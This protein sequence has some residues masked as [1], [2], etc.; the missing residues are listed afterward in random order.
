MKLVW[1]VNYILPQIAEFLGKKKGVIGGWTVRLADM[2]AENPDID[3]TVFYPQSEQR[4]NITGKAGYISFVG[5][6]ENAIPELYYNPGITERIKAELDRI[7]P[8]IVHIWG[9]EYVHTLSMVRAFNR[10]ERTVISIQ[11]LIH[12]LGS[13]YNAG[14]PE[15]I[16]KRH[17]FRDFIRQDSI[18]QQKEKFLKRGECE[19]AALREV[20]HVIGRTGWDEKSVKEVNPEVCYHHAGEI[21]RKAFYDAGFVWRPE[22]AE[23][24]RIFMTQS[25]YPIKGI[26]FV[27]EALSSVKKTFPDIKLAVTGIDMRPDSFKSRIKQDSYGKYVC[28]LI[29]E[30]GLNYNIEFLGE[31]F[32]DDMVKQY[33]RSSA[34]LLPSVME[35]SS[36]SLG[37]AMMLGVPCI[38][39]RTGGT[40]DMICEDEGWLYDHRDTDALS[41]IIMEAIKTVDEAKENGNNGTGLNSM[42]EKARKHALAEYDP[43]MNHKMYASIYDQMISSGLG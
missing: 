37:E 5:F 2:L 32:A 39:A 29:S 20:K 23:K 3:L 42:L 41:R 26:H 24:H 43:F 28:D 35:N 8:D 27:F 21:L 4:D 13:I 30:Y 40:P 33:L 16:V 18:E 31:Q 12:K 25:Y 34:F 36:N 1:L 9:S 6:Y 7:K 10:P 15:K 11:G 38:A 14:L 19:K 22:N 17:T